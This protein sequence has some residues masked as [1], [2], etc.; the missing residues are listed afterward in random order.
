MKEEFKENIDTTSNGDI[1]TSF[2][3]SKL[4][5][6]KG[7]NEHCDNLFD[8]DYKTGEPIPFNWKDDLSLDFF[9]GF[10]RDLHGYK[11]YRGVDAKE[12]YLCKH[13]NTD[14]TRY[15]RPT[16]TALQKWLRELH[17]CHIWTVMTGG[18]RFT[19]HFRYIDKDGKHW[20]H[21]HRED[22][23]IALF[24]SH[25]EALEIGLQE[26]LNLIKV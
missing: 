13:D 2:K 21:T 23:V 8:I 11:N 16:L 18:E 15:L 3:I 19:L 7:F 9:E 25:E 5:K 14:D 1:L 20:P 4:A 22:G 6:D 12:N 24:D 10:A 26:G 17:R